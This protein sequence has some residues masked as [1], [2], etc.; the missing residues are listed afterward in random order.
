T[1]IFW[2]LDFDLKYLGLEGFLPQIFC[3]PRIFPKIF[4]C[5]RV[6]ALKFYSPR[7]LAPNI[8]N[9]VGLPKFGPH[10]FQYFDFGHN[11]EVLPM[12]TSN[13]WSPLRS[14]ISIQIS[15]F[16]VFHVNYSAP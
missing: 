8:Y 2:Y 11:F 6:L 14:T 3:S 5:P 13:L 7:I 1:K 10:N 4:G 12:L 15:W 9:F 16:R